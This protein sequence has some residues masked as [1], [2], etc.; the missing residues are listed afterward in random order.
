MGL[1]RSALL[2]CLYPVD[3]LLHL[4]QFYEEGIGGRQLSKPLVLYGYNHILHPHAFVDL[5]IV[6]S[7]L[8]PTLLSIYSELIQVL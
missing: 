6:L 4:G 3:D 5:G 8:L 7:K 1:I 2:L